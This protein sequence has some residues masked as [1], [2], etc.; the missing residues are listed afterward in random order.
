MVRMLRHPQGPGGKGDHQRGQPA[1]RPVTVGQFGQPTLGT[2]CGGL[3]LPAV[4]EDEQARR[5]NELPFNGLADQQRA[6][7]TVGQ[8][9]RGGPDERLLPLA[10]DRL[11]WG[12]VEAERPPTPGRTWSAAG[13]SAAGRPPIVMFRCQRGL[14]DGHPPVAS[15]R[16]ETASAPPSRART[17]GRQQAARGIRSPFVIITAGLHGL[18]PGPDGGAWS[19]FA[20]LWL[21]FALPCRAGT[22]AGL[23][24]M[25]GDRG[26]G[27]RLGRTRPA[28]CDPGQR[29]RRGGH[30]HVHSHRPGDLGVAARTVQPYTSGLLAQE[31]GTCAS[32]AAGF[33]M[34]CRDTPRP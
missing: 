28:A 24:H 7:D 9:R 13:R 6:A 14:L 21:G 33:V 22:R 30:V 8:N 32:A 12:A 4:V 17:L 23:R 11:A 27:G 20:V 3:D 29:W 16:V 26:G 34:S 18:V 15:C 25:V 1:G 19:S 10:E 5:I 2:R 31:T